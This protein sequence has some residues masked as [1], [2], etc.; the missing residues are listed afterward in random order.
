[1]WLN[2]PLMIERMLP[3]VGSWWPRPLQQRE[4]CSDLWTKLK[5]LTAHSDPLGSGFFFFFKYCRHRI[6]WWS[7]LNEYK[8]TQVSRS[9]RFPLGS[10]SCSALFSLQEEGLHCYGLVGGVACIASASRILGN[11]WKGASGFS[12]LS[13]VSKRFHLAPSPALVRIGSE[14]ESEWVGT[15]IR[16]ARGRSTLAGLVTAISSSVG[17]PLCCVS[18]VLDWLSRVYDLV[19]L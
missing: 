11:N 18:A 12:L 9:Q 6:F 4:F 17:H 3:E 10:V 1:M 13:L 14:W 2:V 8:F 15:G 16:G 5:S 19:S 7:G